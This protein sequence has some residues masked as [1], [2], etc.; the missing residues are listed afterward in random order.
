M[1]KIEFL[2][3]SKFQKIYLK[4]QKVA[5]NNYP[6]NPQSLPYPMATLGN[7]YFFTK[8]IFYNIKTTETTGAVNKIADSKLHRSK[9]F[10]GSDILQKICD[11]R[12]KLMTN[13][14]KQCSV[15]FT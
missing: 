10:T 15:I 9:S 2:G 8:L 6:K 4:Q 12:R 3:A 13:E 11:K 14:K 1:S 7:L 5:K